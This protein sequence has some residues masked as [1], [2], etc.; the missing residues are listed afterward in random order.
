MFD[1]NWGGEGYADYQGYAKVTGQET[2]AQSLNGWE[3]SVMQSWMM[4]QFTEQQNLLTK[5]IIPQLTQMA[6]NPTGFGAS[7]LSAMKSQLQD[8]LGT[9]LSSQQQ[10]LQ[11]NFASQNLAGLGSG[12]EQATSA[13]LGSQAA[14]SLAS[15]N[16]QINIA[17]A[18]AQM[19]QQQFGLQGLM[20]AESALGALP[21]SAG[22]LGQLGGQQFSQAYNM[23]Q[24]GSLWQNI[25]GGVAGAGL[26]AL[27]GG[28][29]NVFQGGSFLSGMGG[30]LSGVSNNLGGNIGMGGT[31]GAPVLQ[32]PSI[33]ATG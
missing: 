33:S 23:A 2:T 32:G 19:Q 3:T 15:G 21:Q 13:M 30:A 28:L 5:T 11:Q 12:V 1:M 27:T 14:S 9:Q 8:T 17:N 6:T 7:A 24:Q 18:Q 25:L 26:S 4:N 31:G 20:G 16:E 29:S 10:S 22:L